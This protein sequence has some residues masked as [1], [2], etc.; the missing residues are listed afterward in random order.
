MVVAIKQSGHFHKPKTSDVP[1]TAEKKVAT[2]DRFN[3][4]VAVCFCAN[5]IVGTPTSTNTL[6]VA[7]MASI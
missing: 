1:V 4:F 2:V 5:R 6:I 7:V 3:R